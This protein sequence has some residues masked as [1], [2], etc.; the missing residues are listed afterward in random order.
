ML[1]FFA[2]TSDARGFRQWKEV[3]RWPKKGSKAFYILSPKHRK[4]KEEE[5]EEEKIILTGFIPVPIFRFEDT[6][7]KELEKPDLTPKQLPPLFEVAQRLEVE[8]RYHSYQG[9]AYGAYSPSQ[10]T[11]KLATHDEKVFFHELAHAAHEHVAGKLRGGQHWDQEIV[12][13]L[14]AATL[15]HLYGRKPQ[16]GRAYQYICRYAEQAGQDVGQACYRVI[17]KVQK[18]LDLILNTQQQ[19]TAEAA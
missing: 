18:V 10:K 17:N 16:D 19:L 2:G 5:T 9:Q 14:S 7:G 3:G 6:E 12:A 15:M 4:V 13:E 11:I 1:V 8:V